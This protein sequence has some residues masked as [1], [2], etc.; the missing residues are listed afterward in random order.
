MFFPLKN[1]LV[2]RLCAVRGEGIDAP[3]ILVNINRDIKFYLHL[4]ALFNKG[5]PL[6]GISIFILPF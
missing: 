2:P 3:E 6:M 5:D 1:P 4:G